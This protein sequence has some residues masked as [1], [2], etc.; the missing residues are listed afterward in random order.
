[1]N[2]SSILEGFDVFFSRCVGRLRRSNW[3][4][5]CLRSSTYH[6]CSEASPVTGVILTLVS[7]YI[8]YGI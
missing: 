2:E 3:L 5:A 1:M 8:D 4:L 7:E 6:Y